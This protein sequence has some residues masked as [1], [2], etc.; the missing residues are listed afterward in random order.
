MSRSA[1]M[2]WSDQWLSAS[3]VQSGW[4]NGCRYSPLLAYLLLPNVFLHKAF[5]KIVFCAA[6]IAAAALILHI[7]S[8][9]VQRMPTAQTAADIALR[10]TLTTGA[11][12]V[13]SEPSNEALPA[14]QTSA[15]Y[16]SVPSA[17]AALWLFNPYTVSISTRGNGDSIVSL[18][19][20]AMLALLQSPN[21]SAPGT[22]KLVTLCLSRTAVAG[23]LYGLLVHWRLF[24]VLYGPCLAAFLWERSQ[25]ARGGRA[26]S[27]VQYIWLCLVF[28]GPAVA[29]F[30]GLGALFYAM[31]GHEFLDETFLY[32]ASRHDPRHN[33]SPTFLYTYL[34]RFSGEPDSSPRL[35][36][37]LDPSSTALPCIFLVT[38][39]IS[40]R[41]RRRLDLSLLLTTMVFVMFNKVSTAQYFVWFFGLL[42]L[43]LAELMQGWGSWHWVAA[44]TWLT[45]Q[46]AW[47][48][49]AYK[50]EFE[51]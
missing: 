32:H 49:C 20:L 24:P 31:Y 7:V 13:G 28:G 4:V 44:G 47:L 16:R 46:L 42:P 15:N 1:S 51:V 6:D 35:P 22:K 50:L 14:L 27:I 19:Q 30:V 21:K 37:W 36:S 12:A 38:L 17:A 41:F 39:A 8:R 18:M 2:A 45:T 26:D 23:A 11:S 29:M 9:K 3:M 25:S 40:L 5:G 48:A 33:F 34:Y 10:S 43:L